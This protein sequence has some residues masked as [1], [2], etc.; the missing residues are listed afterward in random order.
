MAV[1]QRGAHRGTHRGAE[2]R[3]W[4]DTLGIFTGVALLGLAIWPGPT[5]AT[6]GA[7]QEAGNLEALWLVHAL[8]GLTALAGV[9][10]AQRWKLMSFG[11]TLV[12]VAAAGLLAVLFTF[13]NFGLRALLTVLLPAILLL[14]AAFAVGPM[15]RKL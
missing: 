7:A 12:I 3:H 14:V 5:S 4:A 9:T 2:R 10:I 6:A 1:A 8:A 15:P 11:R 13:D